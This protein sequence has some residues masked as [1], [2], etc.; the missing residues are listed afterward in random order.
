MLTIME[1]VGKTKYGQYRV[2]CLCDCGNEK[3]VNMPNLYSG[4]VRSCGCIV[5]ERM[6]KMAKDRVQPND[7][8][9]DDSVVHIISSNTKEIILID[10]DDV[11]KVLK[12]RW[13]VDHTG[14]VRTT[15]N[16]KIIYLHR[17]ILDA[18]NDEQKVDHINGNKLDNRKNNLRF[19]T[20]G[21]NS[22][23][24][25]WFSNGR[26]GHERTS[27]YKGVSKN[28]GDTKYI[29]SIWANGKSVYLGRFTD[30]TDAALAYDKA[31]KEYYGEFARLNF[32]K[33]GYIPAN[34]NFLRSGE[35]AG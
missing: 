27:Q 14:Y 31:A 12:H 32:P 30:E 16:S 34:T 3:E 18:E 9:I 19:C 2:K 6:R 33:D 4:S 23:N 17:F 25:T 7:Y 1:V 29:A 8:Y 35:V 15:I 10:E 26:N 24:K 22:K 20:P 5:K 11:E 13:L 28:I 21:Q